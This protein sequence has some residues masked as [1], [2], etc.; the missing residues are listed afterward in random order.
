RAGANMSAPMD[1]SARLTTR[2]REIVQLVSEG[3]S[4]KE[5][6][7]LLGISVKTAETHRANI[8]RKL[9]VHSVTDLVRYAVRNE[10]V[11]A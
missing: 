3:K 2:E 4:T 10:I 5:V 11:Q 1:L 9:Q 8:I 6:A 7:S